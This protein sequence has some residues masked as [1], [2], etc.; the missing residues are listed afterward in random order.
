M[1]KALPFFHQPDRV[2]P[3][4]SNVSAADL[5]HQSHLKNMVILFRWAG[6]PCITPRFI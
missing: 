5:R 4:T 1:V 2:A 3:K 6:N